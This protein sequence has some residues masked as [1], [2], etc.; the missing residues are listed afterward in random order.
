MNAAASAVH[1]WVSLLITGAD[2]PVPVPRNWASAGPKSPEDRPCRYN[3]GSTSVTWGVVPAHRRRVGALVVHPRRGHLDSARAGQHRAGLGGAVA[4]HQAAAVLAP[5][6]G[7][8]VDVGGD[9]GLQRGGQHLAGALADDLVDQR[10]RGP[11]SRQRGGQVRDY[12]EHGCA[13]PA[14]AAA[15][16]ICLRPL[17]TRSPG[18]YTLLSTHALPGGSTGFKH[19]SGLQIGLQNRRFICGFL[20]PPAILAAAVLRP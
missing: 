13:F 18:R 4:D 14:S 6:A 1:V 20:H 7:E 5:L 3:S 12:C 8:L 11:A 9:L 19:C 16:A 10:G 2:R 17:T 15:P